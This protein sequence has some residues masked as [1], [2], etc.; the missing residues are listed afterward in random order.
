MKKGNNV[1]FAI[2]SFSNP[3]VIDSCIIGDFYKWIF[4]SDQQSKTQRDST[5]YHKRPKKPENSHI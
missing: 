4:F 5:G 1:I 3:H 2:F